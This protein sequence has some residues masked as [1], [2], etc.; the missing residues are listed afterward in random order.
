M[1][2][3]Y[4]PEKLSVVCGGIPIRGFDKDSVINIE[5]DHPQYR[6]NI[7]TQDIV[8]SATIII[9]LLQSSS[10]ND[11]FNSFVEADRLND[12]GIFPIIIK[13]QNGNTIFAC[14]AAYVK[15]ISKISYGSENN[16]REWV[17]RV[18]GVTHL[19]ENN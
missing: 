13:D 11:V 5:F 12:S 15:E 9:H 6:K 7:D 10:S 1:T 2:Y 16:T 17:I 19:D 14:S 4:N 18:T 8:S 3:F